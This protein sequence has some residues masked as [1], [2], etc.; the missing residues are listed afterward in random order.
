MGNTPIPNHPIRGNEYTFRPSIASQP[1]DPA[2]V[3]SNTVIAPGMTFRVLDVFHDWNDVP[4]L[5]MLYGECLQTG[6]CT[7]VTPEDVALP[8]PFF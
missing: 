2:F 1:P 6:Y 5:T 8:V 7:H 3:T 4:G